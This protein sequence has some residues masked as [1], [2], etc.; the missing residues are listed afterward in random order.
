MRRIRGISTLFIFV[1]SCGILYAR[2]ISKPLAV[3]E[4]TKIPRRTLTEGPSIFNTLPFVNESNLSKE[5]KKKYDKMVEEKNKKDIE[6][7]KY[8]S[9]PSMKV[10]NSANLPKRGDGKRI[11]PNIF[12]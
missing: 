10:L 8:W 1:V 2:P 9:Q 5:D 11:L 3:F 4:S 12:K 6:S 7:Q